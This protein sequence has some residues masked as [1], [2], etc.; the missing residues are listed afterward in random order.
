MPKQAVIS[1]ALAITFVV[2]TVSSI[3]ALVTMIIVYKQQIGPMDPTPRPPMTTTTMGPPP[4]K[5]L[6]KYLIPDSYQVTLQVYLYTRIPHVVN[7]TTLEQKYN[8]TGHSTVYFHCTQKI[9]TIYL[10]S[11]DLVILSKTVRNTDSME[12]IG[13]T[14]IVARDDGTDFLEFHLNKTL[15]A[16]GNYSLFTSF[17]GDIS[18]NLEAL[19]VSTYDEGKDEKNSERFLAATQMEPTFARRVFPCFDEPEMK[20]VFHVTIVHRLN[21]VALANERKSDSVIKGQWE[22]TT[23]YPTPRMSTYLFAF[24]VSE[25]TATDSDTHQGVVIKTYARP[26]ATAAGYT[27]YAADVT[28]ELLQFY[29]KY[30]EIKYQQQSLDQIA[31]PD[32][33]FDAMENWGLITYQDTALLY[34]EGVSSILHKEN[35]LI[36]IA[37]ELAH[38]WFGNLV[39]MKWWNEIWLNEGFATY[40]SYLAADHVE[41]TFGSKDLG[42]MYN[43]H[44]AFEADALASSHPLTVPQGEVQT[45]DE[46][47]SM[48]DAIT[49]SKGA[50]VLRMLAD[51]VKDINFHKGIKKYL[52][53]F[54]YENTDQA[55]LWEYIQQAVDEDNGHAKVAKEM[56]PW[57]NQKGY[58]LV[59]INTTTGKAYQK[60][61]LFNESYDTGLSWY[62]PIRV[63]SNIS[64]EPSLVILKG[65]TPE[66][67]PDLV[68][69]KGEWI[70]A[71]VNCIGYFRVNYNHENWERLLTQLE[72]NQKRIPLLNRAQL[73]DDAFNLARAKIVNV[74]L[75]LNATRFLRNETE[76]LVWDSAYRNL[77]YFILMF[78]RSEVYGPMQ[79]YLRQQVYGLYDSLREYTDNS[80]VPEEHSLQRSQLLAVE[81]ACTSGVPECIMMAS[82]LFENWM[83]NDNNTIHPNL[84]SVIYCQAV[85]AGSQKEW[86]FAWDRYQASSDTSE[87]EQLRQALSCTKK[88]WLLNRYLEYTLDPE[89]IRL[90]DVASII[91]D[92]AKNEAGQALAWNFIRAHWEYVSQGDPA[93]LITGVTG[94]F[95]RPFELQEL[96]RFKREYDLGAAVRAVNLAI[97]QTQVNI[98]WVEEHKEVVLEWFKRETSS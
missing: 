56:D 71:N 50:A 32:L 98:Q 88:I 89:K 5:R 57:V 87:R 11:R 65:K 47:T 35:I 45:T 3:A 8:F 75:A 13:V 41:P 16:G 28:G 77:E 1:K 94:R 36:I 24:T 12:E 67:K 18:E 52:S 15:E 42:I 54:K 51:Y 43:L 33:I 53:D 22:Y 10:H 64:S 97:E 66:Q 78:D 9:K 73:I 85:A 83:E 61:F 39:T 96:E 27:K 95:S 19:F 2:L 34:E 40:M 58:P 44:G 80:T 70:L 60:Q 74:S 48:F 79:A 21:T 49:Y 91:I 90:M 82:D 7:V 55:D 92:I 81:L 69:Q 20:A 26:E 63:M 72:T 76:F 29:E 86:E 14:H 31:L 62:I 25:F 68:A 38:Q 93:W 59:T 23:F 4:D 30:F 17:I 46:I 84:R 37:H 6:P